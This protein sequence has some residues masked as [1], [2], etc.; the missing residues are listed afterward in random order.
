MKVRYISLENLIADR[1]V[2]KELVADTMTVKNIQ[3]ELRNILE[4]GRYKSDMLAGYE[5]MARRL[6]PAGAPLHA[7]QEMIR[8]LKK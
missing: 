7:A 6:G 5:D 8:I 2:V 4:N 1:E 3:S